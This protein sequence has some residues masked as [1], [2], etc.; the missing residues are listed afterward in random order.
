MSAKNDFDIETLKEWVR[1]EVDD[2]V[3]RKLCEKVW[4]MEEVTDVKFNDISCR[5]IMCNEI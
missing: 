5:Y 1:L 4:R 3:G 2:D